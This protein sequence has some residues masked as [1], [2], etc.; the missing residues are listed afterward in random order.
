M[1]VIL[2]MDNH[3]VRQEFLAEQKQLKEKFKRRREKDIKYK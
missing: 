2:N 3:V 1:R